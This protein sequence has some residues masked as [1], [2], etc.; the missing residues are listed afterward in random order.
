MEHGTAAGGQRE[1][2][3]V[4]PQHRGRQAH[5]RIREEDKAL[6][7]GHEPECQE[8][9]DEERDAQRDEHE[10]RGHGSIIGVP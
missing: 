3:G 10:P 6:L 9:E 4:E 2:F 5:V 8:Q 7:A 1:L